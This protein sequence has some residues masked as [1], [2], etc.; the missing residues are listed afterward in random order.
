MSTARVPKYCHHKGQNRGYVTVNGKV[1]YFPGPWKSRESEAGYRQFVNQWSVG[2]SQAI[3]LTQTHT[4]PAEQAGITV[5]ELCSGYL[6]YANG[7][8]HASNR[9]HHITRRATTRTKPMYRPR[10]SSS[11]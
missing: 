3:S 10:S 9:P 2:G 11:T 1:M 8:F 5:A 6:T 7:Y 4:T